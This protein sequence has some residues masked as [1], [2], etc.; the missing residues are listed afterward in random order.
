MSYNGPVYTGESG[1]RVSES[2]FQVA[3][4]VVEAWGVVLTHKNR[5][6]CRELALSGVRQGGL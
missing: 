2:P 5:G 4:W 3:G 1:T 6:L